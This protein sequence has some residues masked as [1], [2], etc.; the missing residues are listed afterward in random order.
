MPKVYLL[1]EVDALDGDERFYVTDDPTGTPA[2]GYVTVDTLTEYVSAS[3]APLDEDCNTVDSPGATHDIDLSKPFHY[4][5]MDQNCEFDVTN[6]APEGKVRTAYVYITGEYTPS[7]SE[8]ISWGDADAPTYSD[9]SLF[10]FTSFDGL[11]TVAGGFAGGGFLILS[12]P[13]PPF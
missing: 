10:V 2:D 5:L 1:S 9:G 7:W 8:N 3:F 6:L 11:D 13:P 4:I 12:A